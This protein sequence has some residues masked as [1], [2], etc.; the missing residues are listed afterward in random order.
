MQ[1]LYDLGVLYRLRISK[2]SFRANNS[3]NEFNVDQTFITTRAISSWGKKLLL[4]KSRADLFVNNEQKARNVLRKYGH[5]FE[6]ADAYFIPWGN[7]ENVNNELEEIQEKFNAL[8]EELIKDYPKLKEEWVLDHHEVPVSCYP[9]ESDLR[10]KFKFKWHAYK[11]QGGDKAIP[12]NIDEALSEKQA[13]DLVRANVQTEM[14]S[15]IAEFVGD[16]IDSFRGEI[17]K[18]CEHVAEN[19]GALHGKSVNAIIDKIDRFKSMNIF[20]D[21][22]IAAKLGSL[23]EQLSDA[24]SLN[25]RHDASASVAT[26]IAQSCKVLNDEVVDVVKKAEITNKVQ[27]RIILD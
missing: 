6:V 7:V 17:A 2:W 4:P 23:K 22:E 1:S 26:A 18:F 15:A 5:P 12:T 3:Q 10:S 20:G 27:R 24:K 25:L 19:R 13:Y 8:V 16:Y 11:I 14:S 9:S 21:D